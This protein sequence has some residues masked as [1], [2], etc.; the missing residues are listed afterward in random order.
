MP[1]KGNQFKTNTLRDDTKPD[2]SSSKSEK[3]KPS[4]QKQEA[5]TPFK[6]GDGRLVKITGLFLLIM[7]MFFLVAFTS[8]LFTWQEDQS[9]VTPANGGWHNL[10]K[11]QQELIDNGLKTPVVENWLGKFGALLSNQFIFEW[12]GVASFL[13]VFVFFIIG[14][15]LLFRVRLYPVSKTLGY[16]FF[17]LIFISI[18]L[19]FFHAFISDAPHFL[20]GNFGF[21]SNRLLDAQVGEAGTAGILV[22]AALTALIIAYNID[23]KIPSRRKK[24]LNADVVD[25]VVPEAFE[26]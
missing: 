26:R 21:W 25:A 5:R 13:F 15:R 2:K 14:Y 10:F 7:S 20:E 3:E 23:F 4:K 22:F 12:F 24:E 17:L 11:T 18:T 16:S 9:Y 1:T 8:Y 19:G 6:V